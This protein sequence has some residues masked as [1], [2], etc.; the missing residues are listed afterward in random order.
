M[1]NTWLII[2]LASHGVLALCFVGQFIT[3]LRT[4]K[5]VIPPSAVGLGLT[6]TIVGLVYAIATVDTPL[7]IV[8]ATLL[9]AGWQVL[10]WHRRTGGRTASDRRPGLP[11]VAPHEAEPRSGVFKPNSGKDAKAEA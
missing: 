5:I 3:F 2:G 9:V 4:G 7:I 6:C 10:M 11:V 8:D 1:T